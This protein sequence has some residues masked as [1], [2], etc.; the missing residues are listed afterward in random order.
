MKNMTEFQYAFK[1]RDKTDPKNWY[2]ADNLTILPPENKLGKSFL[3][4]VRD[5]IRGPQK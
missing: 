3:E 5:K 4:K 2:Q 1:I